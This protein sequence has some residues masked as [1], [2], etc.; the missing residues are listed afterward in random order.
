MAAGSEV[1][2]EAAE[3]VSEESAELAEVARAFS[4]RDG[5]FLF[6]GLGIGVTAGAA[7]AYLLLRKKLELKYEAIADSEISAMREH[8]AAKRVSDLAQQEKAMPLSEAVEKLGYKPSENSE[9]PG[10]VPYHQMGEDAEQPDVG[11]VTSIFNQPQPDPDEV[12]PEWNTEEEMELRSPDVP[13][14]IH[15]DEYTQG[16]PDH[17]QH[18]LTFFEGDDVLS[19]ERDR[20]I[21]DQDKTIGLANLS[22]FGHGS[23]DPNI[24]YIRNEELKVDIEIVHSDG[25]YGTEVAGFQDDELQHSSM[26]R[27]SPRRSDHD[28]GD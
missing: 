25:K 2:A 13:Y 15:K 16:I 6:V 12:M 3:L 8:Y 23:G 7:G 18:T 5:S 27:R 21:E 17:E 10:K 24:V 1:V 20:I 19:D 14:V 4:S 22:K 11:T 28:S 9:T 26:K